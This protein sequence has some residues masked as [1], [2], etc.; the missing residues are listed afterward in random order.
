VENSRFEKIEQV[1][2]RLKAMRGLSTAKDVA[3]LLGLSPGDFSNRKGRGTLLAEILHWAI[4]QGADL[5]EIVYGMP[6][7]R[8][9]PA[10][11]LTPDETRLLR[12]YRA[13]GRWQEDLVALAELKAAEEAVRARMAAKGRDS[14]DRAGAGAVARRRVG[15]GG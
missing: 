1:I 3:A 6:I 4:D 15:G 12:A 2:E 11:A 13:A 8:S 9:A 5:N 10:P 7:E 14:P